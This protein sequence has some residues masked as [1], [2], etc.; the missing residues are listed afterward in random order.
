MLN[1]R[2]SAL[3]EDRVCPLGFYMVTAFASALIWLYAMLSLLNP[4]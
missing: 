2:D 4:Q 3:A 1:V